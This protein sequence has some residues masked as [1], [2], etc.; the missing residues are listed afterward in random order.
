MF[1][2]SGSGMCKPR[3]FKT[4]GAILSLLA[5]ATLAISISNIVL[6]N[7]AY[8]NPWTDAEP[9]YC[10]NTNEPYVWTWVASGVWASAP[11][12][13]TGLFAMCL[14]K[15]PSRRTRLF[16]LLIFLSAIVF[17]PAMIILS[18]IEVWRGHASKWNFYKLG[19]ALTEGNLMV[20]DSP[21]RAKFALPL[22]VSILGGIMF[23]MTGVITLV[24]CCCMQSIGMKMSKDSMSHHIY[25]PTPSVVDSDVY[26]PPLAPVKGHGEYQPSTGPNM[27]TRYNSGVDP[28]NSGGLFG[29]FPSRGSQ[30]SSSE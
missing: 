12:F 28:G 23:V 13:L 7:Q 24:Q 20:E 22:V 5:A 25:Q 8:C 14:S 29:S 26:C 17:A 18:S 1:L 15:D 6:T 19:N 3:M 30:F 4:Y 9:T 2:D 11:I 21:F 16:S 27:A 10:S